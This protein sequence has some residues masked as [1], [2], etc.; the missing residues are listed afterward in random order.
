MVSRAAN[1][2]ANGM[3]VRMASRE[4][5][6]SIISDREIKS[7]KLDRSSA[8]ELRKLKDDQ[9]PVPIVALTAVTI[10]T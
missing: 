10:V 7:A 3:V 6:N 4:P 9:Q 2:V 5:A 1:E 8:N